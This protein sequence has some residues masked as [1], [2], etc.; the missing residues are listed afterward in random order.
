MLQAS[1]GGIINVQ[2][3]H[4]MEGRGRWPKGGLSGAKKPHTLPRPCLFLRQGLT[5]LPSLSK[6]W[7]DGLAHSSLLDSRQ[8]AL[9]HALPVNEVINKAAG[10]ATRGHLNR[11]SGA[12]PSCL[13]VQLRSMHQ[14]STSLPMQLTWR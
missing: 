4:S 14:P 6:E 12:V 7:E 1:D 3:G 2:Q 11:A 9:L 8:V 13:N 10:Q 5:A